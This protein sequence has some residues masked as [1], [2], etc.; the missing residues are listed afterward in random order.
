[1]SIQ[2]SSDWASQATDTLDRIVGIVRDRAVGPALT[3]AR[4]VV[5]GTL[6]AI[7]GSVAVVLF[8]IGAVRFLDIWIPG[9]VWIPYAII[10]GIFFLAGVLVFPRRKAHQE[11]S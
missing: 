10:G 1:M 4:A 9:D 5:Y 2:P 7:V 11:E 6:A 3:I 8:A